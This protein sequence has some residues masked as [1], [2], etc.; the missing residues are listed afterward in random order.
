MIIQILRHRPHLIPCVIGAALLFWALDR[1]PYGYYQILRFVTT[2]A[3]AFCAYSFWK[4]RVKAI[5]WGFISIAVLFNPIAPIHLARQ[6]W[7]PVDIAT[8]I[9]FLGAAALRT[10]RTN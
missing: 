3:A 9:V 2:G 8:G 6:T 10:T 4:H 1:H 5:P 7:L